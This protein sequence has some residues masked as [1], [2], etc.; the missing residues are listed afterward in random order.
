MDTKAAYQHSANAAGYASQARGYAKEALE[1][2]AA[3]AGSA[4][5]AAASLARTTEIGRQATADAV[6][7]NAAAGRS[8]GYAKD[9]RDSADQAALDAS[10]ARAAAAQAEADATAARAAAD[11]AATAATEAE[12][13]AKDADKYAK[14]AQEAADRAEKAAKAKQIDTGTVPDGAGQSIGKMFHVINRTE[15]IGEPETLRKTAGC[16]G[17]MNALFYKG[18]CTMTLKIRYKAYVDLYRCTATVLDPTT[19]TCPASDTVYM[20]EYETE[21]L[22]QEVT[23]TITIGE[24]QAGVDPVDILFGHWIKCTEKFS[25]GFER[26]SWGGCAWAAL[27]VGLLFSGKILRPIADGITALDAAMRTGI[28]IA[29]AMGALKTLRLN[30]QALAAL[31]YEANIAEALF[32]SCKRNSFAAG[33]PV[34]MADGSHRPI[35]SLQ[36]GDQVL[37]TDPD[38]G[39]RRSEPVTDTFQHA[40]SHLVSITLADGSTLDTTPGHKIHTSRRGWVAASELRPG[41]LLFRPDGGRLAVTYVRDHPDTAARQVYDLTVN[42][43]HTFYVGTGGPRTTDVLVHNCTNLDDE[44]LPALRDYSAEMH[45]LK[46]HVNP[47]PAEAFAHAIRKRGPNSVWTNQDVAQQAVDMAMK[48]KFG[49]VLENGQMVLDKKAVRDYMVT[50]QTRTRPGGLL[51]EFSGTWHGV[52][53]LGKTYHPD[54]RTVT[55]AGNTFTVKLMRIPEHTGKG[56]GGY[57]VMTAFPTGSP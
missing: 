46:E 23:R 43:L 28:G 12:Q 27:D 6:A 31:E 42:N 19:A 8:E 33:T 15:E 37:A 18:D 30:P 29:D 34:L 50:R 26:G 40:S 53:S 4:A 10:A 41:D 5:Q 13:A 21:E 11:R 2:A 36:V 9:A 39:V 54:G 14:E 45:T 55:D 57:A 47:T 38:T 44:L 3:A 1:Y 7:A 56:R 24:Y 17:F 20:G 35:N 51:L 32:T 22:S 49:T 48:Q 16:E 52:R 25:S